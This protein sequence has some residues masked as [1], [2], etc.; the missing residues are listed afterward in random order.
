MINR[1]TRNLFGGVEHQRT[2]HPPKA[3]N[4]V[5]FQ[6]TIRRPRASIHK[7]SP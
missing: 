3:I 2:Y 6:V 5:D 1:A 7:D 4:R